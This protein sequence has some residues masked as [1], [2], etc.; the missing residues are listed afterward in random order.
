VYA[1]D[2]SNYKFIRQYAPTLYKITSDGTATGVVKPYTDEYGRTYTAWADSRTAKGATIYAKDYDEPIATYENV[3]VDQMTLTK[4]LDIA[5]TDSLLL[6]VDGAKI[7]DTDVNTNDTIAKGLTTYTAFGGR[8]STV[9]IYKLAANSYKVVVINTYVA[10]VPAIGKDDKT[11][12][13]SVKALADDSVVTTA[14]ASVEGLTKGDIVS[15]NKGATVDK[16]SAYNVTKL[17]GT[18]VEVTAT[19]TTNPGN[20][21]YVRINGEQVF[22]SKNVGRNATTASTTA[23]MSVVKTGTFYY[24]AYGNVLYYADTAAQ[25]AKAPDGYAY[26]YAHQVKAAVTTD[27][28]ASTPAKAAAKLIDISTGAVSVVTEAV[29]QKGP[30]YYLANEFGTA[31]ATKIEADKT[32]TD[33][34]ASGKFVAYYVLDDGSYVFKDVATSFST[35]VDAAEITNSYASVKNITAKGVAT[36][37]GV[38]GAYADA[39]TKVTAIAE[40]TAGTKYT[41]TSVVGVNNFTTIASADS[42]KTTKVFVQ[43]SGN[44]ITN[45]VILKGNGTASDAAID[46][47]TY[48]MLKEVGDVTIADDN[49]KTYH[50]TFVVNG[51]DVTYTTENTGIVALTNSAVGSAFKLTTEGPF[52]AEALT[53]KFYNVSTNE[54]GLVEVTAITDDYIVVKAAGTYTNPAAET[55]VYKSKNF[56]VTDISKEGEGLVVGA[57]V[58]LY[59]DSSDAAAKAVYV[60]VQ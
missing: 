18:E 33:I 7:T 23:T 15:F 29:V 3:K 48:G 14:S 1:G 40:T 26:L 8:G 53:N 42:S 51:N 37:D 58:V 10:V 12:T 50:Y 44:K 21:S 19:G 41:V 35:G 57:N 2:S 17:E 24:D 20:E 45:I 30:D 28:T 32:D 54:K 27:L 38:S 34:A 49:T 46:G 56:Q 25:A 16:I 11:V 52:G 36:I 59:M 9:E 31:S 39:N 6:Y 5:S 43:R 47:N 22:A 13:L 60:V 55:L 4:D